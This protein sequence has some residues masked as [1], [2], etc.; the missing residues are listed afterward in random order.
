[1]FANA[2]PIIRLL[3]MNR[4]DGTKA[5][6]ERLQPLL[7]PQPPKTGRPAVDHRRLLNGIWWSLRTGAPWRTVASRVYRWQRAGLWQRVFD[8]VKQ[9]AEA[10]GQRT[11]DLHDVDRPRVRAQQHAAGAT[12]GPPRPTRED[13]ARGASAPR[14]TAERTAR[15]S[16]APWS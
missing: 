3:G 12:R 6:W 13:A 4:G 15:G 5:Q 2:V 8:A 10:S 16:D 7:P 11:G 14:G 9:P 1:V